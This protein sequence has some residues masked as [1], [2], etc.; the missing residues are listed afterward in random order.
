MP[1]TSRAERQAGGLRDGAAENAVIPVTAEDQT[2]GI[3]ETM[4]HRMPSLRCWKRPVPTSGAGASDY[5][6]LGENAI[7]VE[8]IWNK[9]YEGTIYHGRLGLGIMLMSALDNALHDL[10]G[11]LLGVPAY[12]LLGGAARSSVTPYATLLPSMPPFLVRDSRRLPPA[13]RARFGHRLPRS[14][15]GNSVL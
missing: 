9:V 10:R 11:K 2:Y 14:Q 3:G 8:R 13:H 5:L 1:R 4:L 7:E 6:V 15:D 12:Q